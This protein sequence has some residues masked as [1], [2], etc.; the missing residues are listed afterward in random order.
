MPL[1]RELAVGGLDV[2]FSRAFWNAENRVVVFV[3]HQSL[4]DDHFRGSKQF[5]ADRV[6]LLGVLENRIVGNAVRS[7]QRADGLG[8]ARI[9]RFALD[10]DRLYAFARENGFEPAQRLFDA[11]AQFVAAALIEG[12]RA[13]EVVEHRKKPLEQLAAVRGDDRGTVALHA[14]LVV[15]EVGHRER[16]CC[17]SRRPWRLPRQAARARRPSTLREDRALP[18]RLQ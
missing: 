1:A 3:V 8:D 4:G 5:L 16:N 13:L 15:F 9:E 17:S 7:G 14:L 10:V 18:H 6:A 2:F 12:E 11:A